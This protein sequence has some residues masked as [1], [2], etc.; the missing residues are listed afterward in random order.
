MG[1]SR[2]SRNCVR[3]DLMT[4]GNLCLRMNDLLDGHSTDDDRHDL[5]TGANRDRRMNGTDDRCDRNLDGTTDVSHDLRRNDLLDDPNL[6]AMMG[7]NLYRHTNGM[8]DR[9]DQKM[10]GTTDVSHDL[11]RNDLPDDPNLGASRAIRNCVRRGLNLDVM[12]GVNLCHH[13]NDRLDDL[14]TDVNLLNRSCAPHDLKM[15]ENFD[16]MSRL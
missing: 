7:G 2:V 10:D 16:V 14:K 1:A 6:V 11:R 15:V 5:M 3:H 4:G 9:N 12:T 8:D 13:M